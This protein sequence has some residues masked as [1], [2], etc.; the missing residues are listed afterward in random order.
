MPF[1]AKQVPK[2]VFCSCDL[3]IPKL[4]SPWKAHEY[5]SPMF[6]FPWGQKRLLHHLQPS[7]LVTSCELLRLWMLSACLDSR[8]SCQSSF[9]GNRWKGMQGEQHS[10]GKFFPKVYRWWLSQ[11]CGNV[12]Q[13]WWKGSY[14]LVSNSRK[15]VFP[16]PLT[17]TV[18]FRVTILTLTKFDFL[19]HIVYSLWIKKA[20][21]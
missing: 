12:K 13:W 7:W 11:P 17:L 19:M 20:P 21:V 9:Q 14:K 18:K 8:L 10:T 4:M 3:H 6:K 16:E 2:C 5:Y 1:H 15:L